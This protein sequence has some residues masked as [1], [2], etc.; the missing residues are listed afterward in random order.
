MRKYKARLPVL[1]GLN[2]KTWEYSYLVARVSAVSFD[3]GDKWNEHLCLPWRLETL[4][5]ERTLL[6]KGKRLS[7]HD[8]D[9]LS[10]LGGRS[11][12]DYQKLHHSN[13]PAEACVVM[14]LGTQHNMLVNGRLETYWSRWRKGRSTF[15]KLTFL[16]IKPC[17]RLTM[18]L[19]NAPLRLTPF[20]Q[21]DEFKTWW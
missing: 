18:H 15:L 11:A 21:T 13:L 14:H 8:S 7:L 20:A 3:F 17:Y 1:E 2:G 9:F 10:D 4:M 19:G 6:K 12:L 5:G 16:E